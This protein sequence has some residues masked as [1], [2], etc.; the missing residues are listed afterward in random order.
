MKAKVFALDEV[1]KELR[2]FVFVELYTDK[3]ENA[4]LEEEK[5]GTD[6]LPLYVLLAPDGQE[7]ARLD[8][9]EF[10]VAKFIAFLRK[11]KVE[12][13]QS[14]AVASFKAVKPKAKQGG[15]AELF[16]DLIAEPSPIQTLT[17][18]VEGFEVSKIVEREIGY[19]ITIKV[20]ANAKPGPTELKA[21]FVAKLE[22]GEE[23][24]VQ[25][26][27]VLEVRERKTLPG[28]DPLQKGLLVFLLV[29]MAGGAISLVMPCVYPL[30]PI[31]LTF[32]IKQGAGSKGKSSLLALLY[33][34]GII[35]TFT[36]LGFGLSILM[37]AAGAQTFAANPGVNILIAIAFFIMALSLLGWFELKLP[38]FILDRASGAPKQGYLGAFGLGLIFS[39]VTFTCTIPIAATL[40]GLAATGKPAWA[41]LGMLVYS[42]TMATPFLLL[43]LFPQLLQKIPRSG[44][45]L[46]TMKVGTGF[47]ELALAFYYFAKADFSWGWDLMSRDLNLAIWIAILLAGSTW[48]FGLWR[49]AHDDK[50]EHI[51]YGRGLWAMIFAVFAFF[52]VVGLA[53]RP[54]GAFDAILPREPGK[55]YTSLEAGLEAAKKEKKLVFLEFTGFS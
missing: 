51:S 30:I 3:P 37:G 6:L 9:P 33:A 54:L 52:L 39:V 41:L 35:I 1:K 50:V 40:M 53:G 4:K 28:E 24:T 19:E 16:V 55:E 48:L 25:G 31:T 2:N 29:C 17:A 47:L 45:W 49:F 44:G 20:P 21:T 23:R 34:L 15:T 10:D 7:I 5:F 11:A 14:F 42:V 12:T 38:G 32:F 27:A 18:K 26:K 13:P 43:A 8:R 36:G 46:Q 22:N